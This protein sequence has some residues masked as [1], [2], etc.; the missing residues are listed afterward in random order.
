MLSLMGNDVIFNRLHFPPDF[1][2][3]KV[4]IFALG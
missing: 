1:M 3:F 4:K 2:H